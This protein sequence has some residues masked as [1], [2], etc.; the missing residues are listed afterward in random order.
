MAENK[1]KLSKLSEATK[2]LKITDPYHGYEVRY[3]ILREI[4]EK[5]LEKQIWF[6]SKIRVVEEDPHGNASQF[7]LAAADGVAVSCL[8]SES[9]SMT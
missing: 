5:Q 1:P 4:S 2:K 6:A 7:G 8:P 3:P 9:M